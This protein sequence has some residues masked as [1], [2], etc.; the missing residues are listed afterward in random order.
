M[1]YLKMPTWETLTIGTPSFLLSGETRTIRRITL[2]TRRSLTTQITMEVSSHSPSHLRIPNTIAWNS[3]LLLRQ[4]INNLT[5]RWSLDFSRLPKTLIV[6]TSIMWCHRFSRNLVIQRL[7]AQFK[8]SLHVGTQW[9]A[10]AL[11]LS[12]GHSK[13]P[14]SCSALLFVW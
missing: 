12:L 14:V 4:V 2:E 3:I 11:L 8:L 9:S 13:S 1:M 7:R 6:S 10:Q 5:Q